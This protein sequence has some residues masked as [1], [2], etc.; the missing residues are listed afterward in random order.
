M[1][2]SPTLPRIDSGDGEYDGGSSDGSRD[3]N[4]DGL[5][6]SVDM[7]ITAFNLNVGSILTDEDKAPKVKT[8]VVDD[9]AGNTPGPEVVDIAIT[10][11]TEVGDTAIVPVNVAVGEAIEPSKPASPV[12]ENLT[13]SRLTATPEEQ[14]KTALNLEAPTSNG[15]ETAAE[16]QSMNT[17][18]K[19]IEKKAVQ[20]SSIAVEERSSWCCWGPQ[21]T[22]KKN[23][24]GR[25]RPSSNK[26]ETEK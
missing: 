8:K 9:E 14:P 23:S 22:K 7:K 26:G 18:A 13:P 15:S 11:G 25:D 21:H 19:H 12:A 3:V 17:P 6:E 20:S 5:D 2:K 1:C 10:P 4:E 16:S 24:V